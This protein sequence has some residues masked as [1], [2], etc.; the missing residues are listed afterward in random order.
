MIL[1]EKSFE[2]QSRRSRRK[3]KFSYKI[4]LH[5]SAYKNVKL[6]QYG[7]V[8]G[9]LQHNQRGVHGPNA[10]SYDGRCLL[11]FEMTVVR[12]SLF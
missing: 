12:V 7:P 8:V 1:D 11:P 4:Y 5:P 10:V 2:L 6:F 3:L 9:A